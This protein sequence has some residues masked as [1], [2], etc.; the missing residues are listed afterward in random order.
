MLSLNFRWHPFIGPNKRV[1]SS[2]RFIIVYSKQL[3]NSFP[4]YDWNGKK[5]CRKNSRDHFTYIHVRGFLQFVPPSKSMSIVYLMLT[6]RRA[7]SSGEDIYTCDSNFHL[8]FLLFD[9]FFINVIAVIDNLHKST[10]RKIMTK[11]LK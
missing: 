9:W 10:L 3:E 11:K 8:S 7:N 6:L 4:T 1:E 5:S 2:Q